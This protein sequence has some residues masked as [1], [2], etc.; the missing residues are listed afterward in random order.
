MPAHDVHLLRQT[1]LGKKP[2]RLVAL[3]PEVD[4]DALKIT[5]RVVEAANAAALGF[6]PGEGSS[7]GQVAC[8]ICGAPVPGAYVKSEAR[9]QRM[10]IAP[11]AAVVVKKS[12]KGAKTRRGREYLPVGAYALP[13]DTDCARRIV[14]LGIDPLTEPLPDTM[15]ITGGTCMVYGMSKYED[16]FTP[17]QLLSLGTLAAGVRQIHEECLAAGMEDGRAQALATSLGM[18]VNKVVDHCSS[19]CRWIA[20]ASYEGGANT[21]SRQSLPM[22]WDFSEANPF[23]GSSGDVRKYL[24]ETVELIESLSVGGP[25]LCVR[26]SATSVPLRDSCQDAVITDPPYYDN[27]SYA[28]L[29]D[30]F[31]VWLKRSV[32]FLY[33]TDLGGE[34]TPK[35][36]EAVVAPYRHAGDRIKARAY[37]ESLMEQSFQEAHR[38]LK[39]DGVM[40]CV[41]GHKTTSGWATLIDA[42]RRSGF[43]VTEAWPVETEMRQ[44]TVSQDTAS[45]RTSIFLV[46]RK[47]DPRSG[48]GTEAQALA[49]LDDIIHE[50][51]ARLQQVGIAGADLVIATVGA[52][53]GAL[54]RYERVEQ[55]NGEP[56]P[57]DRFLDTV[58]TRVL[59]AIF[60][61]IA[62]ADNGTRF[63]V[64]AQY[65]YGYVPV[66]FDEANNL[67]RMCGADFDGLGG[68]GSGPNPAVAKVKSTVHLRDYLDRGKDERLGLPDSETN[69]AADLIDVV[70]ALLWRAEHRPASLREF[71]LKAQP[72]S[73]Q[74]RQV[75]QALAGKALRSDNGSAKSREAQ[76]AETLMVSWRS[77]VDDAVML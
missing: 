8:R 55:A 16:L 21:F 77:L 51:L 45:L 31:Y 18:V 75:V 27:I 42:L 62:G 3:K 47:R 56:V 2:G 13:D 67:A 58:Q 76:A 57:A 61:S 37:Y 48:V 71:L 54:T 19:L 7:G 40:V 23:G 44:R 10:G 1:W 26:G 9:A 60:G 74:L 68:L 11:I 50:R 73:G 22:V 69:K 46:A 4:H 35:R 6:D 53:L 49:D 70:H 12:K 39:P 33:E 72:D 65:S 14:A 29:S 36:S 5:Y 43:V 25:A 17:R 66:A 32:G 34:L 24:N 52:G 28:D 63:Y 59:D 15:R 20:A 41:Y 30:F 64:A 38:V